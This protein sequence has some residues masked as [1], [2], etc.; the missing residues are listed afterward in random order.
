MEILP[1]RASSAFSSS[2]LT[3]EAGRSIDFARGDLRGHRRREEANGHGIIII[4]RYF[5]ACAADELR[6]QRCITNGLTGDQV[7]LWSAIEPESCERGSSFRPENDATVIWSRLCAVMLL[8][9]CR[10]ARIVRDG[11]LRCRTSQRQPTATA[12]PTF[13]A[14]PASTPDPYRQYTIEYLRSRSYGGGQ[15]EA[16]ETAGVRTAPSHAI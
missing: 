4:E 15:I 13:T 1:A 10:P 12:A 3:T 6:K 16:Y 14:T 9:G 11:S 5:S 7:M 2:S 8:A